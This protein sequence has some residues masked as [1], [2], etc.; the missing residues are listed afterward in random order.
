MDSTIKIGIGV[1]KSNKNIVVNKYSF[2][3]KISF[4]L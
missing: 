3:N 1:Q 4:F 2:T